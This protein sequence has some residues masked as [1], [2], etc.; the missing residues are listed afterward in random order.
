MAY[1]DA[2]PK[3]DRAI[4]RSFLRHRYGDDA[5]ACL[6]LGYTEGIVI[7]PGGMERFDAV[8]DRAEHTHLFFHVADLKAEWA[9]SATH[10]KGEVT[11]ASKE[12][13]TLK[14]GTKTHVR[15]CPFLWLDCDAEKYRGSD[16]AGA[17]DHY[18]GEGIRISKTIDDRLA[19]LGITP[20]AKWRSGAGWQA[21]VLLDG[22]LAPDEAESLV[23]K[24][25]LAIGFD[26]VVKNCNRIL[27]VA[28]SVNWKSGKD[29]RVP[30]PCTPCHFRENAITSL[31]HVR[32]VLAKINAPKTA[33]AVA[34]RK[35][36]AV[37]IDFEA[38]T[39]HINTFTT[40]RLRE[41][42]VEEHALLSLQ[43]GSDLVELDK[44]HRAI[45][46]RITEGAYDSFSDVTFAIAGA[47]D[48]AGLTPEESAG[49]LLTSTFLG[50]KHITGQKDS[51]GK[52]RAI[53]RA[54]SNARTDSAGQQ[55]R[56]AATASGLPV[57]RECKDKHGLCPEPTYY[58]ARVAIGALGIECR[59][60]VF[61]DKMLI[62]YR[63]DVTHE[64]KT[65]IGE[66]SGN[67]LVRLREFISR[68]FGFDPN[69]K[70][71]LDAVKALCLEHC[72]DPILD[73][74][75][76]VQPN[77]DGVNRLETWMIRYLGAP[78]TRLLRAISSIILIA[79]V[80]R[81]RHPG[82]KFDQIVVLEGEEGIDK[83][84]AINILAGDEN[85]SDQHILDVKE[86][87]VQE[88]LAG[89]WVYEIADLAGISKAEVEKVKAFASRRIDRARKAYGRLREDV[90]RRCVFFATTNDKEYLQSQTGN[91]RFWPVETS[92]I[93]KESLRADRDQL[94][95]EA[96]HR[97]AQGASIVLDQ[98]L[99][100][101]AR[102]QQEE[103]R[104]KDPWE[105][106]LAA[107]PETV[108]SYEAGSVAEHRIIWRDRGEECVSSADLL[109]FV[110]EVAK[111]R[112]HSGTGKR[113]STV[114]KQLGWQRKKGGKVW[115]DGMAV[116]G[117]FRSDYTH[118]QVQEEAERA[119]EEWCRGREALG[120][121]PVFWRLPL[122]QAN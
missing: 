25:H 116:N 111:E 117:Y 2:G 90:P 93:D 46:H 120:E 45:G 115:I 63:G 31:D 32:K 58:N 40:D 96:A 7:G 19:D 6:V 59:Y 61:H 91:R 66:L 88:Q 20:Y 10:A 87:E 60:D 28:G 114:M 24:L 27:R 77:W 29:G 122:R 44:R 11:S 86:R 4:M 49:V 82:T 43:F 97:E 121:K 17:E 67:T 35:P 23:E 57:W 15:Q 56:A 51:K 12:T 108:R 5:V 104:S 52:R 69:E 113:L 36:E 73:Y 112:Q 30:A 14:D 65:L 1:E 94:W 84:T 54:I 98:E 33:L 13:A 83:S 39:D 22:P 72:F 68:Q 42:G 79:A 99:W 81:A 21:L 107:I 119:Y 106:Q 37:D 34:T 3:I 74:V 78:D 76:S 8:L 92:N 105:N 89:V 50:N 47:L 48:R 75:D 109:T 16:P 95:A 101:D 110:L 85:F 55:R 64:V 100:E 71:V 26:P 62:G 102:E 9:D 70:H 118:R 41:R 38:A 80:R 18:I 53:T 103:R